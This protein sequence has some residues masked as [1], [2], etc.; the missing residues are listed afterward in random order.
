MPSGQAG[1]RR[2]GAVEIAVDPLVLPEEERLVH[3]LEGQCEI[4]R[5]A[6]ADVLE[7]V[8]VEV[9]DEAD[10]QAGG[11][12][13]LLEE[14]ELDAAVLDRRKVVAGRPDP[15]RRLGPPV[16]LVGLEGFELDRVVAEILVAD[17]VEIVGADIDRQVLAPIVR[18]AL[19]DDRARRRH[20]LDLVGAGAERR[21]ERAL[22][23]V[24]LVAPCASVPSQ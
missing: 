1:R 13:W 11:L 9:E 5:L 3:L 4:E 19:I 17:L 21:L 20:R 24:A 10:H 23:D 12:V 18:H 2:A 14:L 22:R 8:A 7:D 6:D 15:R 16:D